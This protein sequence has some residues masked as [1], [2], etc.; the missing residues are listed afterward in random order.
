MMPALVT[1]L[2]ALALTGSTVAFVPIGGGT[3]TH[4]SITGT[5]LLQKVTETCRQVV[6]EEGHEF[7]PTVGWKIN[8]K[9]YCSTNT[10]EPEVQ[11]KK[12][13]KKNLPSWHLCV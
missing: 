8:E 7:N 10:V 6:E 1:A 5:A 12:T 3:S 9:N 4:I 13:D 11:I 2:L